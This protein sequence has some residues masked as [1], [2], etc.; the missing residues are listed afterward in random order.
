M[1]ELYWLISHKH[2][3]RSSRGREERAICFEQFV[4]INTHAGSKENHRNFEKA[5]QYTFKQKYSKLSLLFFSKLNLLF[6][7]ELFV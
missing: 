4:P 5:K 3:R 1:H 7:S 2:N 6:Y